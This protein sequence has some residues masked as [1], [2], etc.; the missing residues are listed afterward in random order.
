MNPV[1]VVKELYRAFAD[2]DASGMRA[3]LDPDVEW[4]EAEGYIYGGTYRGHEAI[5]D[6]VVARDRAEWESFTANPEK[7]LCDGQDVVTV[8]WYTGTYKATQRSFRA[9]FAH[10]YIVRDN[11]IVR[12]EQVVDSAKVLEILSP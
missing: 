1:D 8:G 11:R 3:V 12:F 5:L 2:D 10:L 4:I 6:G 9:R 7:F